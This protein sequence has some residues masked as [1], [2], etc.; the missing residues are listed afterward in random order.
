MTTLAEFKKLHE[1]LYGRVLRALMVEKM[2]IV[3]ARDIGIYNPFY[4]KFVV[5]SSTN[6]REISYN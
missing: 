5:I 3:D 4:N 6:P 2:Y 1:T